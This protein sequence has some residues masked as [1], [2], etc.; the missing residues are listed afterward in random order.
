MSP[1]NSDYFL[2]IKPAYT[3]G[4]EHRAAQDPSHA[5]A[6]DS[7]LKLILTNPAHT[8]SLERVAAQELPQGGAIDNNFEL[9]LTNPTQTNS[10]G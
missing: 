8:N 5:K 9:I 10:P 4:P 7:N 2:D 1:Q 6:D 3:H